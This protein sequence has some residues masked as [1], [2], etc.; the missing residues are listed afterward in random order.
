MVSYVLYEWSPAALLVF[1]P[2]NDWNPPPHSPHPFSDHL[3]LGGGPGWPQEKQMFT[4]SAPTGA[5]RC[6]P[7][8]TS[9]A[10]WVATVA[11]WK[12][13]G[14]RG[15]RSSRHRSQFSKIVGSDVPPVTIGVGGEMCSFTL[16]ACI[17]QMRCPFQSTGRSL[18]IVGGHWS[19]ADVYK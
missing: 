1:V 4:A 11:L 7:V 18:A 3:R 8:P 2:P 6:R 16:T 15:A 14:C 9:R 12:E 17:V 13:P 10:G 5:N 19:L